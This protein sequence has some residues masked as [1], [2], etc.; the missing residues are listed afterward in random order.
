MLQKAS[1][2]EDNLSKNQR[3]ALHSLKEDTE[4]I[5]IPADKGL[6]TV[7]LNKEDY[8]KK[9]NNH[10]DS[11]LDIKLQKYPTERIKREART[12]LA[13]LRDN[14]TINQSLYLKLKPTDS[15]AMR[16]YGLPKIH[17]ATI[18][19]RRIISYSASPLFNLLTHIANN[20]KP[21]TLLNKQHCKNS[22]E[23]SE[24][25]R[26]HTIEEDKIMVSFDVEALYTN[27]P[28]EDALVIIKEL[29]ENDDSLSDQTPLSPKNVLDLLEFLKNTSSN[30]NE[31]TN[32][33]SRVSSVSTQVQH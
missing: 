10:L 14:G 27:V 1:P 20:L 8:I 30:Q 16:F 26:A 21:Y 15:Q 3:Q 25:V 5:I 31:E 19:V 28:I 23:F 33:Q 13:I 9:Y 12:N 4:I 32:N 29:L 2:P 11:G 22:K 24:F 6:A 7:I 18:P 17:K